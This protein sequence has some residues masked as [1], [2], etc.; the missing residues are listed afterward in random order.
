M[1]AVLELQTKSLEH[2]EMAKI[3]ASAH[4]MG[5]YYRA[6]ILL[7]PPFLLFH[8]SMRQS[9]ALYASNGAPSTVV[10]MIAEACI[11]A[12]IN[13]MD[14]VQDVL[15]HANLPK[16]L[17]VVL[18]NVL[19]CAL[20]VGVAIFADYD[21]QFPLRANLHRCLAAL[22]QMGDA[23]PI[24]V[25]YLDI[26]QSL[27]KASEEYT[28]LREQNSLRSKC[29]QF[30]GLIGVVHSHFASPQRSSHFNANGLEPSS[31]S[32]LADFDLGFDFF[33]AISDGYATISPSF[34]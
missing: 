16:R 12:V 29:K 28:T 23:D 24:D 30:D 7:T 34:R 27:S 21:Q 9:Q 15:S 31:A 6:I 19:K 1:P 13:G 5:A 3:I 20:T 4:L 32:P 33:S 22:R 17:P 11:V 8:V 26:V 10:S 18:K 2:L 25:Q 14:L